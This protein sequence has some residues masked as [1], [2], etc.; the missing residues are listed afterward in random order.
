MHYRQMEKIIKGA[1]NHRRLQI[2][3]LLERKPEMSVAEIANE[4]R[5]NFKTISQHILRLANSGLVLK[6]NSASTV[7]HALSPR[8]K[9]ILKFCRIIE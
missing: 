5:V 9:S 8:G 2:M 4:L 6:R 1:A 3:E 7:R